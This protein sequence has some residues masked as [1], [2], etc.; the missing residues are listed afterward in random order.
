M[1]RGEKKPCAGTCLPCR[2]SGR[3]RG[4]LW[5][6]RGVPKGSLLDLRLA[7][8]QGRGKGVSHTGRA[9]GL[10]A[11]EESG[12][13]RDIP[14]LFRHVPF[15]R[16]TSAGPAHSR[17]WRATRA[18]ASGSGDARGR[19]VSV[20]GVLFCASELIPKQLCRHHNHSSLP[21]P[22][23]MKVLLLQ[24]QSTSESVPSITALET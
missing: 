1:K 8:E 19:P 22:P 13:R 4:W 6:G 15:V 12:L 17:E 7:G 5:Q 16:G 2:G 14:S 23:C 24:S 11:L 18:W 9:R 21:Q 3:R 20:S 10:R